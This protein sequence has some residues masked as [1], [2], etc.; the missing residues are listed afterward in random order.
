MTN[1]EEKT[2][3]AFTVNVSMLPLLLLVVI[4][5]IGGGYWLGFHHQTITLPESAPATIG[6]ECVYPI[7]DPYPQRYTSRK[8]GEVCAVVEEN[9]KELGELRF[10]VTIPGE[11]GHPDAMFASWWD[12]V[13]YVSNHPMP[14]GV[15]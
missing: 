3:R 1:R 15:R 9:N 10:S 8:T 13:L 12:S 11:V 14:R 7:D 4:L 6:E 2:G 5:D